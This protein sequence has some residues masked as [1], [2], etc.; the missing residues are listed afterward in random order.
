MHAGIVGELGME[1]RGQRAAFADGQRLDPTRPAVQGSEYAAEV[2]YSIHPTEWLEMRPN[3]Q[4]VHH[5]GGYSQAEDVTI[6]G[7]KAAFIL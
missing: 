6:L 7:L 5:P 1:R 2:Y 3:V 4:F